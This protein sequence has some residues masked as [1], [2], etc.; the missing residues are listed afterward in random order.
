MTKKLLYKEPPLQHP[1]QTSFFPPLQQRQCFSSLAPVYLSHLLLSPSF[2]VSRAAMCCHF[3]LRSKISLV[4]AWCIH[5][6]FFTYQPSFPPLGFLSSSDA[7]PIV[8]CSLSLP[9]PLSFS[10][11]T[12][13]SCSNSLPWRGSSSPYA[14]MKGY[15]GQ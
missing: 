8:L 15:G 7:L 14:Q 1:L 10:L 11:P 3:L 9:L 2:K 4:G 6:L 12:F 13:R 5:N